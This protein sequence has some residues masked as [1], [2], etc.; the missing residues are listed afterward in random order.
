MAL[1]QIRGRAVLQRA[2]RRMRTR[3]TTVSH[4]LHSGVVY[5]GILNALIDRSRLATSILRWAQSSTTLRV[6]VRGSRR[7]RLL[8]TFLGALLAR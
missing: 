7:V 6:G 8:V 5:F 2:R 3:L 4:H 1:T